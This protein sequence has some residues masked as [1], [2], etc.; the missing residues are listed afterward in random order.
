MNIFS[1]GVQFTNENRCRFHFNAQLDKE[2]VS[3][4][5]S[6]IYC[7]LFAGEQVELSMQGLQMFYN[8]YFQT[9]CYC[10]DPG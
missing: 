2:K 7:I 1:F 3:C 4:V 8:W 6:A 10:I 9:C 5:K